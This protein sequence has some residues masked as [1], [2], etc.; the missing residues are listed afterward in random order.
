MR[1][2]CTYMVPTKRLVFATTFQ[3][4]TLAF[5]RVMKHCMKDRYNVFIIYIVLHCMRQCILIN[6]TLLCIIHSDGKP[7]EYFPQI[8]TFKYKLL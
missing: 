5:M 8:G 4:D 6:H 1:H 2:T 7:P 3:L